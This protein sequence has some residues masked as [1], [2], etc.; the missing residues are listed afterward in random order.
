M[1]NSGLGEKTKLGTTPTG[2]N[3]LEKRKTRYTKHLSGVITPSVCVIVTVS[4]SVSSTQYR[5]QKV[6][7]KGVYMYVYDA[8][9][10]R[11][12]TLAN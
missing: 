12:I 8:L 4:T 7:H 5:R 10:I 9:L 1:V 11:V 2:L 3:L 6:V